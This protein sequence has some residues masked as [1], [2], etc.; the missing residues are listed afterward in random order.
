MPYRWLLIFTLASIPLSVNAAPPDK[1]EQWTMTMSYQEDSTTDHEQ[2]DKSGYDRTHD[3]AHIDANATVVLEVRPS[4]SDWQ[5]AK[6]VKISGSGSASASHRRR[7]KS[8]DDIDGRVTTTI[9]E[10]FDSQGTLVAS[11]TK[12]EEC[13]FVVGQY[14]VV[15]CLLH[16]PTSH[17][18]T[19][20][21]SITVRGG[22]AVTS[23]TD[24][25]STVD[26]PISVTVAM[27][28]A[29][30]EMIKNKHW[31][32]TVVQKIDEPRLLALG[33]HG[34][35]TQTIDIRGAS[36][37][38]ELI[39][40]PDAY[41]TWVPTANLASPATAG[42]HIAIRA[43]LKTKNGKPVPPDMLANRIAFKLKNGSKLPGIATNYPANAK[44]DDYDL[45]FA[46]VD[47]LDELK[48][49]A[50]G[51]G[52]EKRGPTDVAVANVSAYDF[53]GWADL[54]VTA[55][56]ADGT[57]V[58]GH[59][60]GKPEGA[61]VLPKRSGGSKIADAWRTTAGAGKADEADDDALPAGTGFAGDGFTTFEEY[62][63]IVCGGTHVR[64]D[65]K[66]KDLLVRFAPVIRAAA[67]RGVGYFQ[68]GTGL[69]VHQCTS[70]AELP[71][72]RDVTSNHG[73]GPHHVDQHG[74]VV[75]Q[76]G[77]GRS[78]A[79]NIGTPATAGHVVVAAPPGK[80]REQQE[81]DSTIAHEL[82]HSVGIRHHG[83]GDRTPVYWVKRSDG[84]LVERATEMNGVGHDTEITLLDEAGK[85][86]TLTD[87]DVAALFAEGSQSPGLYISMLRGEHSGD[88][89]CF[90]RYSVSLDYKGRYFTVL[91]DRM[92]PKVRRWI[93]APEPIGT[94]LC[95]S[96]KG[97]QVNA[98]GKKPLRWHDDA[99]QGDCTHQIVVND[100]ATP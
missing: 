4:F 2:T 8:V 65:P 66:R 62:R 55:D 26:N 21:K 25:S 35:I 70:D 59:I 100:A 3:R 32:S 41:D 36:E 85:P 20:K 47:N 14:I 5:S 9:D 83:D 30:P 34:T 12:T 87:P 60:A 33:V 81:W 49:D 73:A 19:T 72:S 80:G 54:V 42:S 53:G 68:A 28:S 99:P 91:Q 51:Q 40:T 43:E 58:T 23:P 52:A 74:V 78:A 86:V 17:K 39:V 63:G 97:T 31:T 45:R 57:T 98:D 29:T 44:D 38:V 77:K 64:M 15:T 27:E 79:E 90:M 89:S 82:G 13:S 69:V 48:V 18:D 6:L 56:L 1:V 37:P 22:H 67:A 92:S 61:L 71:P 95:K 76:G 94:T 50:D 7:M 24:T 88:A 10:D 75:E 46:A 93:R 11:Q 96:K 84:S 16:I